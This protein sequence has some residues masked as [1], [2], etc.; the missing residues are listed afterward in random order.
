MT[1]RKETQGIKKRRTKERLILLLSGGFVCI[2]LLFVFS[3]TIGIYHM[4]FA[5][6]LGRVWELITHF[7]PTSESDLGE[8]VIYYLRMPRALAVIFVGAGLATAGAVMQALIRNPLVD[9]YITGISSGA[10]F[11]V[12]LAT[13]GG[14]T[15]GLSES[16]LVPLV[17]I[18]G[19]CLAFG[20]TLFIAEMAG[21]K[22]MSYVLAGVIISTGLSAATTLIIY[23]NVH[24]YARI[25]KW[26]FGSFADLSWNNTVV[27]ILGVLLPIIISFAYSKKLNIMLLGE[28]Q[29]Q[30][31][32]VDSRKLKR[33]L[34]VLIAVLTAFC[35]AYCGVIGFIGLIIPHVCRM[36]VGGDHR[37]LIPSSALIGGLVM[38]IADMF[39]RTIAAPSE[40]PIGA[41]VAVIGVPFFLFLMIKEGKRYAV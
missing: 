4:S 24:D 25:M 34:M 28:E 7:G 39:C 10:S 30:Y 18:V 36:V 8:R 19:A 5:D 35:V 31:L 38:L 40:L 15:L 14:V 23:F 11:M 32:G 29:A 3:L 41:L 6:A 22:A 13:L 1:E 2:S 33:G 21:G 27:I 17:A 37:L 20:L 9:P 12:V 16:L 26:M